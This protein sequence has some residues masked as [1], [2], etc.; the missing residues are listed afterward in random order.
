MEDCDQTPEYCGCIAKRSLQL[1]DSHCG[2]DVISSWG[3]VFTH[4][5]LTPISIFESTFKLPRQSFSATDVVSQPVKVWKTG[6]ANDFSSPKIVQTEL[7]SQYKK[8]S[9]FPKVIPEITEVFKHIQLTLLFHFT[10]ILS[11]KVCCDYVQQEES[12]QNVDQ[13]E[14]TRSTQISSWNPNRSSLLSTETGQ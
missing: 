3:Q 10:D 9:P 5:R 7:I 12:I 4:Y 14:K 13:R 2:S 6:N 8:L 11:W 1:F